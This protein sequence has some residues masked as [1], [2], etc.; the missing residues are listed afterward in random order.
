MKGDVG[1]GVVYV[2]H[3]DTMLKSQP[4][5]GSHGLYFVSSRNEP[6]HVLSK[7]K[8]NKCFSLGNQLLNSGTVFGRLW[9]VVV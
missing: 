1:E 5:L 4:G 6:L 2:R 8:T 7:G 9:V 3:R